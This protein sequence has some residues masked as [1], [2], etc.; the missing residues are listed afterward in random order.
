MPEVICLKMF[1]DVAY[2]M[3]HIH[4]LG[5]IHLDLNARNILVFKKTDVNDQYEFKVSDIG[6]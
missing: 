6:S 1:K 4:K 2:C 5:L 3:N